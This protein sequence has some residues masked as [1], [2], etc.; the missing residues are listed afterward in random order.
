MSIVTLKYYLVIIHS[1]RS[2]A[3]NYSTTSTDI[4]WTIRASP[5]LVKFYHIPQYSF[6]TSTQPETN[7]KSIMAIIKIAI[8]S[9]ILS[10]FVS[11]FSA[12]AFQCSLNCRNDRFW[13]TSSFRPRSDFQ[14]S[15]VDDD[16][17]SDYDTDD[18]QPTEQQVFVDTDSEDAIIRDQLKRELLL[19]ASVTKRGEFATNEEK[20]IIIDL[21]TQLE[22][23]DAVI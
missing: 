14:M 6:D 17:P 5:L 3:F 8:L 21:V 1:H 16:V 9:L 10:S 15:T 18:L 11:K 23:R 22:V 13:V 20:D 7:N 2:S 4:D 12:N 19:L